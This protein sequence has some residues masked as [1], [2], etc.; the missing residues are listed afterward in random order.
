MALNPHVNF[1]KAVNEQ[2][3]LQDL[4]VESVKMYGVDIR[5]LPRTITNEDP[6]Y[7]EDVASE[8]N[9]NFTI[10]MYIKS[11]DGY[12]GDGQ[13]LSKFGIEIRHQIVF[14]VAIR[15]WDTTTASLVGFP[16]SF[17]RPLEGDLVYF[18][19]DNKIFQIKKVNQYD[20]F[21]Q[22]GAMHTYDL[23]CEVFEYASEVLN[24]GIPAV[25]TIA[26]QMSLNTAEQ[27][28]VVNGNPIFDLG[29]D[30]NQGELDD[31]GDNEEHDEQGHP[32]IDFTKT[33]SNPFINL[34]P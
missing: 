32:M 2:T 4:I 1:H 11:V 34:Q 20:V 19:M 28:S 31:V 12:Q 24:T 26:D 21:Y 23:T 7:R 10:E 22:T 17:D 8:Y 15:T 6:I 5:Y 33:G 30:E 16:Q 14:T 18:E 3:L 27:G 29:F 25:D 9:G 13:F